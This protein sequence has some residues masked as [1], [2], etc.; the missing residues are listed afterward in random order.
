MRDVGKGLL[1]DT[2]KLVFDGGIK[3]PVGSTDVEVHGEMVGAE[4]FGEARKPRGQGVLRCRCAEVP[5]AAAGLG[6]A[7]ANVGAGAIKL[8]ARCVD[9]LMRHE[10]GG[11]FELH[12]D[13]DEALG[14]RI[15]NL[16]GDA[17]AFGKDGGKLRLQAAQAQTVGMNQSLR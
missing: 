4:L 16:A 14:E 8:V 2:Q 12:G 1:C 6:D 15:V 5:Y 17:I 10:L 13:P 9:V 3:G 11:K 7:F